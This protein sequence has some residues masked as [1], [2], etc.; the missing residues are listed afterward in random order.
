MTSKISLGAIL[1]AVQCMLFSCISSSDETVITYDDVAI[2]SFT[3]GTIKCY[4]TT[5]ASDGTDSTYS[6]TY[7]GSAVPM[8]IDQ[9]NNTIYNL[10][11]LVVGSNVSRVLV[12]IGTKN[13]GIV[14]FANLDDDG[15]TYY[16]STDSV[17]LST[18]R[19]LVV[20]SSDGQ[21]SREY[22]VKTVVHKEFA[23]SFTWKEIAI[24]KSALVAS[25]KT[26]KLL[27]TSNGLF[28]MGYDG[29]KMHLLKS[30]DY[31]SWTECGAAGQSE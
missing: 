17:D 7:S 30:A 9:R 18:E 1:L 27:K 13:A 14:R 28:L 31:A 22:T 5:K 2:T 24:D 20:T 25:L 23:D 6:Y 16:S 10:D 19:T 29:E 11:S 12:S 4:R 21:N 8:H 3:L 15:Y 26:M